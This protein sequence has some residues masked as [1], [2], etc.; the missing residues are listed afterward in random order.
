MKRI[1]L[2]VPALVAVLVLGSIPALA[3]A[4]SRTRPLKLKNKLH[5][6]RTSHGFYCPNHASCP[7]APGEQPRPRLKTRRGQH[8]ILVTAG[9]PRRLAIAVTKPKHNP[10]N[11]TVTLAH[12]HP[13]P[14]GD[15][16]QHWHFRLR[17]DSNGATALE[18]SAAYPQGSSFYLGG[19][20]LSGH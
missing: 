11:G 15:S 19:I 5:H 13:Q 3:T 18:I 10:H 1:R 2:I 12:V 6:V 8:L 7:A 20:R 16:R 9:T 4:G 14:A 17:H